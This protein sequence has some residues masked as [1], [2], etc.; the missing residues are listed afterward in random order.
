MRDTKYS[1]EREEPVVVREDKNEY[2]KIRIHG[3]MVGPRS[4][5]SG[6]SKIFGFALWTPKLHRTCDLKI[7]GPVIFGVGCLR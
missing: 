1:V 4:H 7:C 6:G 5:G 2:V 3:I